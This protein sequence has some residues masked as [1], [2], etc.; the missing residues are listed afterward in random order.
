MTCESQV[1]RLPSGQGLAMRGGAGSTTTLEWS[2]VLTR[3]FRG[4]VETASD[5]IAMQVNTVEIDSEVSSLIG[6]PAATRPVCPFVGMYELPQGS[7]GSAPRRS[8]DR[9]MLIYPAFLV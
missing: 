2:L 4:K 3:V 6:T 1:I 9:R 8:R 5:R 7:V